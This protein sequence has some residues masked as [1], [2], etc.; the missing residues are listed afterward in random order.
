MKDYIEENYP[1]RE[2]SYPELRRTVQEAWDVEVT[3]E[4]VFELIASMHQR[5]LHVIA[6][7]G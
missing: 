1:D 6:T 3:E 7:N 2:Y 4:A 5:C